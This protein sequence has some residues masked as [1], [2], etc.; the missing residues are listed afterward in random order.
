MEEKKKKKDQ[1]KRYEK[2]WRKEEKWDFFF[3]TSN[4]S[5]SIIHL[6]QL[7]HVRCRGAS[8]N[9]KPRLCHW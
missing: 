5:S 4:I 7:D 3:L 1:G 9:N 2:I 8:V 6:L